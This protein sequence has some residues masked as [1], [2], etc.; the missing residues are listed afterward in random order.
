M[1]E[2]HLHTCLQAPGSSTPDAISAQVHGRVQSSLE[3]EAGAEKEVRG[4]Q[5]LAYSASSHPEA[6]GCF[7]VHPVTP[8]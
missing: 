4:V 3:T 7:G 1:T 6:L 5:V 8:L 2:C